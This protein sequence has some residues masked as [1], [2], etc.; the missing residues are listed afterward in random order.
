M[1]TSGNNKAFKVFSIN[2]TVRN[3]ERN[4][5]F[6][7]VFKT[8]NGM[9][10]DDEIKL[11]YLIELVKNGV[12]KFS[13]M[14]ETI[15]KKLL[16][17]E[18]LNES[19][20]NELLEKNPQ[21]TGFAGRVMTQLR[22]LK[23]QGILVFSGNKKIPRIT[24]SKLGDSI[25]QNNESITDIYSKIMIGLHANNP[26]R[27]SMLNESR[28]FLNTLFVIAELKKYYDLQ[29]KEFKGILKDE[30]K[31]FVLG[32]KDCDY[33]K[34]ANEIIEFREKF[35]VKASKESQNYIEQYLFDKEKLFKVKFNT[36][37]DYADE[38][39]RKFEMT[40]LLRD[41]KI[42]LDFSVFNLGK[43]EQ[44]LKEY[45]NYKFLNFK[46]QEEYINFLENIKLP[47]QERKEVRKNIIIQK[48][49]Y[50]GKS[51][52]TLDFSNLNA[53]ENNLNVE[54]NS[55]ILSKEIRNCDLSV[56]IDELKI[57]SDSNNGISKYESLSEPLRLE[58]ILALIFGKK[59]GSEG[60]CSNLIYNE[61]G[62]PISYAPGGKGDLIYKDFLIEAT[63]IKNKNQQLN[64]ETTS[65]ARHSKELQEKQKIEQRTML[66]APVIHWDVALFFKFCS[67]E[68]DSKLAPISIDAFLKL[69]ENSPTLDCFRENYDVVIKQL[70]LKNTDDYIDCIN[71]TKY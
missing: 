45:K 34:C 27:T 70:L 64:A 35:G 55:N 20:I 22:A 57:L 66:I 13:I 16:N 8:F 18:L 68:F 17:D 19:E 3:P 44:I 26:T 40:G 37:N 49:K 12:Y 33:K 7:K 58:Y 41:R 5:E 47:W 50:L 1:G 46:N 53:L 9:V 10:F 54:F 15:K 36:L 23:D 67:K 51:E 52:K 4:L 56:L 6:L 42:Y 28:P 62:L 24:I 48:A 31:S 61:N 63:M 60:L 2:T 43:V 30:F 29:N 14:S 71:K 38:M 11:K 21:K 65:I 69:I 39:Q 32:M 25:I 59:F